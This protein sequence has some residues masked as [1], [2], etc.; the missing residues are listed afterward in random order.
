MGVW[1]PGIFSDD[2][3]VDVRDEYRRLI[4]DGLD[5]P[6]A[7]DK[8]LASSPGIA[9][10]DQ[11]GIPFW[12][13][14]A[15][16]QWKIGRLEPRVR[17]R[18]VAILDAGADLERWRDEDPEL[19]PKRRAALERLR[20]TLTKPQGSETRVRTGGRFKPRFTPGDVISYRLPDGRYTAF[21][22]VGSKSDHE[23]EVDVAE[24]VDYLGV[25]PPTFEAAAQLPPRP[26]LDHRQLPDTPFIVPLVLSQ[27]AKRRL[28][29]I[30]RGVPRPPLTKR[31]FGLFGKTNVPWDRVYT[32]MERWDQMEYY[33]L[34]AF[35]EA[36]PDDS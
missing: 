3:A 11:D 26:F 20:E 22:I 30:G 23:G 6:D 10:D 27:E 21:R 24:L 13:A 33:V 8:V 32:L 19:E 34:P 16:T 2:I 18:A 12:L 5:G 36:A 9:D 35:G 14:L 25:D 7:T 15:A 1:G 31:C 28:E 29:V 4:A 17:D